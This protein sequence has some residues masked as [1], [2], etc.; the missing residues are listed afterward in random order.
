[1]LKICTVSVLVL[2]CIGV[3]RDYSYLIDRECNY[4]FWTIQGDDTNTPLSVERD[5]LFS[6]LAHSY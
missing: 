5:R 1:M 3:D 4:L 6:L 2:T